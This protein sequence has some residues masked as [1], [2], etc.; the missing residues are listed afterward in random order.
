[1]KASQI[2]DCEDDIAQMDFEVQ[3]LEEVKRQFSGNKHIVQIIDHFLIANQFQCIV[4]EFATGGDLYTALKETPPVIKKGREQHAFS[5]EQVRSFTHGLAEALNML[6]KLN[7]IH[8]DIK[9]EN[10][11][12]FDPQ[13]SHIKLT[14]FG[15]SC[16]DVQG[17]FRLEFAHCMC[18]R[19][20]E[21]TLG[22]GYSK[23]SDMWALGCVVA[24]MHTGVPIFDVNDEGVLLMLQM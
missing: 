12:L 15:I 11:L 2:L 10:V 13:T 5:L 17:S 18:N 14:D 6:F 7:I 23:A 4:L 3:A 19:A 22:C 1:M 21:I 8:C 20:P 16:K 9:L 24:E